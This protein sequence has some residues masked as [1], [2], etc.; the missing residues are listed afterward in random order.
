MCVCVCV[1]VFIFITGVAPQAD[2]NYHRLF[3]FVQLEGKWATFVAV[4][5]ISAPSPTRPLGTLASIDTECHTSYHSSYSWLVRICSSVQLQNS[6]I[7][8][9]C[10]SPP[11]PRMLRAQCCNVISFI[12][13]ST[14]IASV[15]C[16]DLCTC[17]INMSLAVGRRSSVV[18]WEWV[19]C[20]DF[21]NL[22]MQFEFRSFPLQMISFL[23][24]SLIRVLLCFIF[25]HL[26]LEIV[27]LCNEFSFSRLCGKKMLIMMVCLL[28]VFCTSVAITSS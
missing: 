21:C 10:S 8:F 12:D 4:L 17:S 15:H 28:I 24:I 27:G 14:S 13:T 6:T 2:L 11:P 20:S 9:S 18:E 23:F 19:L 5:H 16:A 7:A 22:Q 26:V 3:T 25:V 1:P